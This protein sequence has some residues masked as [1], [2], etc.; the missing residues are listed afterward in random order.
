MILE[1]RLWR[2]VEK[3]C[4]HMADRRCPLREGIAKVKVRG[5]LSWWRGVVNTGVFLGKSQPDFMNGVEREGRWWERGE[6]ARGHPDFSIVTKSSH[7]LK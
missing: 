6:E 4:V 1:R 5:E 2:T 3:L 7:S